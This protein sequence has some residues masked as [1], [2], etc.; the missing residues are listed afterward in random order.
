M[1]PAGYKNCELFFWSKELGSG[2]VVDDYR[3]DDEQYLRD[4]YAET[5]A[6]C[7]AEEPEGDR[8]GLEGEFLGISEEAQTCCAVDESAEEAAE[9]DSAYREE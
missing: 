1:Y 2:V 7:E 4:V 9:H 3:D 5:Y 8:A 6:E